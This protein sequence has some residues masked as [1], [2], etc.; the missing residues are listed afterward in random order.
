MTHYQ[1]AVSQIDGEQ[2][3]AWLAVTPAEGAEAFFILEFHEVFRFIVLY[4]I[5]A[6]PVVCCCNINV[7]TNVFKRS[8]LWKATILWLL[9]E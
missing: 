3:C 2:G 6:D 9:R 4:R 7:L 5:G 8:W 1:N